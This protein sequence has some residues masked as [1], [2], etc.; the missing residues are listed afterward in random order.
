MT[1]PSAIKRD[2]AWMSRGHR[3]LIGMSAIVLDGA[4]IED[5]VIVAAGALVPPRKV[6]LQDGLWLGNP[7]RRLRATDGRAEIEP[8][9]VF[10]GATTSR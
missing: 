3:C 1:S 8:A 2:V 7:A 5:E 6:W 4:V 9:E 10:R